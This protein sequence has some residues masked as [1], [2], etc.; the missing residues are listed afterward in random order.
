MFLKRAGWSLW[1]R[2]FRNILILV[3]FSVILAVTLTSFMVYTG[4]GHQVEITEKAVANAITLQAPAVSGMTFTTN[5]DLKMTDAMFF[6]KSEYAERHNIVLTSLDMETAGL[7]PYYEDPEKAEQYR[8]YM[9]AMEGFDEQRAAMAQW[10]FETHNYYYSH[11]RTAEADGY[12]YGYNEDGGMDIY[13]PNYSPEE[14]ASFL[15]FY[16]ATLTSSIDGI[17]KPVGFQ[18][19]AISDSEYFDTFSSGGYALVEGDHIKPENDGAYH[20][21]ISQDMAEM[22]GLHVG[23]KMTLEFNA[24]DQALARFP[25]YYPWELTITGIFDP[26]DN[27]FSAGGYSASNFIY[28]SYEGLYKYMYDMYNNE[29]LLWVPYGTNR[30]TVYVENQED[31]EAFIEE[32]YSRFKIVEFSDG[33][34]PVKGTSIE[35][36]FD[37]GTFD[38]GDPQKLDAALVEYVDGIQWYDPWYAL[39]VDREWYDMVAAPLESVHTMAL[40]MGVGLL[41]GAFVAL[42]LVCV[43]NIR[44]RRREVGILLAMGESKLKVFLQL[45]IEQALPLVLAAVIGFGVGVPLASAFGN[46]LLAG[47]SSQVNAAYDQDKREYLEAQMEG[48][49]YSI[50]DT[51][52]VRS[53]ANVVAPARLQFRLDPAL[54]AGYFGAA[55]CMLFLTVF[56]QVVFLLRLS[57]ARIL[58]KRN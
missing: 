25:N 23:D 55:L 24:T 38:T 47:K 15:R 7:T 12:R 6:V 32:A 13:N 37:E 52:R 33:S 36:L 57:P 45:F 8:K 20:V 2:K 4:T 28:V 18:I 22:N 54:A 29:A 26:P 42:L 1:G 17:E 39:V 51:Q 10:L 43:F 44:S 56:I 53:A 48:N 40:V 41:A 58:L 34:S 16:S 11:M 35:D 14:N 27:S 3:V 5:I 46:T 49:P 9:E 21:L 19:T 31:M 50:E 30:A